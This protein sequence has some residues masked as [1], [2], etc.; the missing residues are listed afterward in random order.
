MERVIIGRL[1]SKYDI[2]ADQI[3]REAVL[4]E[5]KFIRS[6]IIDGKKIITYIG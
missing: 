2:N 1:Q 5:N 3:R 4:L 6:E